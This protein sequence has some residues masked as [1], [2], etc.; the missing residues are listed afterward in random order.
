M[1]LAAFLTICASVAALLIGAMFSALATR[2][3]AYERVMRAVDLVSDGS[4]A[5]ARHKLG[6]LVY[7]YPEEITS[8]TPIL[9]DDKDVRSQRVADLFTILWAA[10][11]LEATRRSL[12]PERVVGGPHRLLRDSVASW[13]EWWVAPDK[14]GRV[15]VRAVAECLEASVSEEDDL[16]GLTTL[17][18]RWRAHS[19]GRRAGGQGG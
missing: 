2:R 12:G 8:G 17:H 1:P 11:R 19:G 6:A 5:S 7:D 9:V 16:N 18:R 15:R 10:R 14:N 4:V 3:A 13:V